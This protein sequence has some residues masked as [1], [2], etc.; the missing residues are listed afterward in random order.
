MT[1]AEMPKG[2]KCTTA[3]K[4]FHPTGINAMFSML[5]NIIGL[6]PI[7]YYDMIHGTIGR[8]YH[9]YILPKDILN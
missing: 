8:A 3:I 6:L 2:A 4:L 5:Y 7:F 9:S 1:L